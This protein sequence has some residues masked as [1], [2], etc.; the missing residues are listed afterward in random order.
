MDVDA[1]AAASR[2]HSIAD[3]N[4]I[5]TYRTEAQ[6]LCYPWSCRTFDGGVSD[7]E[8]ATGVIPKKQSP[9]EAEK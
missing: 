2:R 1:M 7:S 9:E 6:A 3:S 8:G 4:A 5:Q